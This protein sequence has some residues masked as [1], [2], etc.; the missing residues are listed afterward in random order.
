[1]LQ[2]HKLVMWSSV[3]VVKQHF[4]TNSITSLLNTEEA[5]AIEAS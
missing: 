3:W 4:V 5:A 1:M 2:L